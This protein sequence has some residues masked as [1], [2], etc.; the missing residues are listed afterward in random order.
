[1]GPAVKSSMMH[2]SDYVYVI[3]WS[4]T[5]F[6]LQGNLSP[7][8]TLYMEERIMCFSDEVLF[9]DFL[10]IKKKRKNKGW[11]THQW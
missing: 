6:L 2:L 11:D 1:M 5:T 7:K 8:N 9:I 4:M 3:L 10:F